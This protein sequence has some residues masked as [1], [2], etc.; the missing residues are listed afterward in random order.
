MFTARAGTNVPVPV[1]AL[2]SG[3][4][5]LG[6]WVVSLDSDPSQSGS[7]SPECRGQDGD[8]GVGLPDVLLQ[9]QRILGIRD[10]FINY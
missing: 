7:N 4:Q 9:V 3:G 10:R 6:L 8:R 5:Q 1:K 2:E